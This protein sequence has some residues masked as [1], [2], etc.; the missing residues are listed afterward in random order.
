MPIFETT[1]VQEVIKTMSDRNFYGRL[2][3]KFDNGRIVQ[4]V[5]L[6]SLS[7]LSEECIPNIDLSDKSE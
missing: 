4:V 3:I 2:E 7:P 6:E 5:R 1:R